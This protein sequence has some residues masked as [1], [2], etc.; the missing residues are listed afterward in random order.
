[1]DTGLLDLRDVFGLNL[2]EKDGVKF[3]QRATCAVLDQ[4]NLTSIANAEDMPSTYITW[5][6]LPGQK[7]LLYHF[8]P[9]A[10][11]AGWEDVTMGVDLLSL[12]LSSGVGH[13]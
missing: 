4:D 6:P 10:G 2:E 13:S 11:G 3:R 7:I 12:N 9:L 5:D 8:G 1:M